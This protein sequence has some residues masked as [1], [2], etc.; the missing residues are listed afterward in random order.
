MIYRA[1]N[2]PYKNK[3]MDIAIELFYKRVKILT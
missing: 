2:H 3:D 1:K